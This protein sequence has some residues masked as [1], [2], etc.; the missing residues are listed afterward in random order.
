VTSLTEPQAIWRLGDPIPE[1][2]VSADS[3]SVAPDNPKV[4]DVSAIARSIKVT[5][6]FGFIYTQ[7]E[8]N[9]IIVG[10]HRYKGG[11]AVGMTHFPVISW[12]VD[13]AT[14][15]KWM[16]ADNRYAELG[17]WNDPIL[18]GVLDSFIVEDLTLEGTGFDQDFYDSL[19]LNLDGVDDIPGEP[20]AGVVPDGRVRIQVG[21]IA[22]SVEHEEWA[23]FEAGLVEECGTSNAALVQEVRE[24]LGL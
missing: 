13:D 1:H 4:G 11:R 2:W 5:G 20:P 9:L 14:R 8:T 22:F 6:F 16:L 12:N 10:A 19:K 23:S 17:H 3:I 15:R 21:P 7:A 18:A 24:R